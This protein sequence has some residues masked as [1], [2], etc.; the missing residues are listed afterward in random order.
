MISL[1]ESVSRKPSISDFHPCRQLP[2]G[3][4]EDR[5]SHFIMLCL[6]QKIRCHIARIC[7]LV[8]QA[9]E[10]RFTG[11]RINAHMA[12]HC[13]FWQ[14]PQKILPGHDL[15]CLGD[16]LLFRRQA[17]Q[18]PGRLP[19]CRFRLPPPLCRHQS[20]RLDFSILIRRGGHHNMGHARN[21]GRNHIHE[22]RRRIDR[23]SAWNINP[24]RFRGVT[25]CPS[26]VPSSVEVNQLFCLCLS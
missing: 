1:R 24:T 12:V 16:A 2:A 3:G 18:W 9:P 19:P 14:A 17:P 13:F 22:H 25:F 10:S 23:F 6:R 5:G 20:G 8:R 21:L 15:V 26:M 11:N 4:D 7:R